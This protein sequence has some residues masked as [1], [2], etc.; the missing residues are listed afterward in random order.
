M[1]DVFSDGTH[2]RTTAFDRADA[3][4]LTA[5]QLHHA[6]EECRPERRRC[7]G[8][9]TSSTSRASSNRRIMHATCNWVQAGTAAAV[10][11]KSQPEVD[12][13][14]TKLQLLSLMCVCVMI[15][16]ARPEQA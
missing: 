15:A 4:G 1:H 5:H 3:A 12:S 7:T 6:R 13:S 9:S 14:T 2:A 8:H 10:T 16:T 11:T